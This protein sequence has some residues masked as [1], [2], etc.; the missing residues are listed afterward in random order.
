MDPSPFN[1]RAAARGIDRATVRQLAQ[2]SWDQADPTGWF[3]TLYANAQGD[4]TAIPWAD[5]TPNPN[6]VQWLQQSPRPAG[7]RA[8]V[9]GCGLGDDA[10]LLTELGWTVTGFDVSKSAID[11]CQSRFQ[12]SATTYQVADLLDLP[13][14]WH[15]QFDFV[16]E[17]YTLQALPAET[18]AQ[19]IP[20]LAACVAPGGTLLVITRGRDED[21]PVGLLPLPLTRSELLTLCHSG[22]SLTQF[23]DYWD[24]ETPPARR[25]RV[26]YCR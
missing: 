15:Q 5:L 3:E 16:V 21:E 1:P 22:L 20:C 4:P 24:P 7:T 23:E 14:A 2:Q 9:V 26:E 13:P 25:F 10:E 11:W 8:L 18:L 12:G 6:L 19:A 17:A